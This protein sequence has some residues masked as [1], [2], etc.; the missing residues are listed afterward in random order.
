MVGEGYSVM[1]P[2]AQQ[3]Q[4]PIPYD[5]LTFILMLPFMPLMMAMQY[6]MMMMQMM[7][8]MSQ[9][10]RSGGTKLVEL[11]RDTHGNIIEILERG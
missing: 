4:L 11:R 6:H 7:M 10:F 9:G 3:T 2:A 1:L 5:P 8:Q